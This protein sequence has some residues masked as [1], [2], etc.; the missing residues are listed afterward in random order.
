[1]ISV[2]FFS[3]NL[4]FSSFHMHI[5]LQ[6]LCVSKIQCMY[7]FIYLC[8]SKYLY[9]SINIDLPI[10]IYVCVYIYESESCSVVSD[11]LRPHGL[12]SSWSSPGQNSG[13][14]S[15]S[16]LQVIFPTQGSN[17]GLPHCRQILYQLSHKGSPYIN[18]N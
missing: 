10:H 1:M 12:Y 15:L 9:K 8:M 2:Q 18:M 13:L 4:Y 7:M 16:L 11:F 3:Q 6:E 5:I 14:G 17:P